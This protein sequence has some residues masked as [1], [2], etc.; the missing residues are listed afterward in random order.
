MPPKLYSWLCVFLVIPV[1]SIMYYHLVDGRVPYDG[2]QYLKAYLFATI[3]VVIYVSRIDMA[4]T[5]YGVLTILS[6]L[7]V[8][9][10]AVTSISPSYIQ[11]LYVFGFEY[12]CM[13]LGQR[14]YG[15]MRFIS[16]FYKTTPMIV[17]AITYYVFKV[18]TETGKKK[19]TFLFLSALNIFAMYLAG[20]R[21]NILMSIIAPLLVM[22]MYSKSKITVRL[23]VMAA[24]VVMVMFFFDVARD[25]FSATERSNEYKFAYLA[26]YGRIFLN[27]MQLLFGQGLGAYNYW[28]VHGSETA[29]TELTFFELFR[30]YGFVGGAILLGLILSPLREIRS[31]VK[32]A[33]QPML[34]GY[35]CYLVMSFSNPL[36]FSSSGI[37]VLSIVMSSLFMEDKPAKVGSARAAVGIPGVP[38]APRY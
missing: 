32:S 22:F 4:R 20:T 18:M 31:N 7:I 35:G 5:F 37:L 8:V 25:M 1:L 23:L 16:I 33:K 21:N 28:S 34:L 19:T 6:V 24:S 36:F 27:P 12:D 13:Q 26:D 30:N 38:G 14:T 29:I 10:F 2:F 3:I 17:L 9:L 11:R 15:S